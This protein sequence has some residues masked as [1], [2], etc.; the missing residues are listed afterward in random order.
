MKV[1]G[2]EGRAK[3]PHINNTVLVIYFLLIVVERVEIWEA[4]VA[5]GVGAHL[6]IREA[7]LKHVEPRRNLLHKLFFSNVPCQ[8]V[9]GEEAP[10]VAAGEVF[11]T[12][13][14]EVPVNEIAV[15]EVVGHLSRETHVLARHRVFDVGAEVNGLYAAVLCEAQGGAH[16]VSLKE[17]TVPAEESLYELVTV[18]GGSRPLVHVLGVVDLVED[19]V[20]VLVAA[21]GLILGGLAAVVNPVGVVCVVAESCDEVQ[22]LGHE[23][24]VLL[25][26][27]V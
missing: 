7:D 1:V 25:Q 17:R 5:C 20:A 10:A 15:L 18:A 21:V 16:V 2:K 9:G 19:E 23:V 8:A 14:A 4:V 22:T 11:G 3:I 6:T 27:H 26:R 24:E 13:V 12:G